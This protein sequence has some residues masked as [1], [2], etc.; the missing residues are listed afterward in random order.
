MVFRVVLE[1]L[2][3]DGAETLEVTEETDVRS[4]FS[5][6]LSRLGSEG[7]WEGKSE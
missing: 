1:E 7:R 2:A 3:S 4:T 5:V 6:R